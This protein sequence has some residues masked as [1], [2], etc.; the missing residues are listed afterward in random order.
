MCILKIPNIFFLCF[1]AK[2]L[3]S[4]SQESFEVASRTEESLAS[5]QR[6]PCRTSQRYLQDKEIHG[7]IGKRCVSTKHAHTYYLKNLNTCA[8]L[9]TEHL[10]FPLNTAMRGLNFFSF[11][12][13]ILP[14]SLSSLLK[15]KGKNTD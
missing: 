4:H 7:K 11:S 2:I 8:K 9:K 6:S 5:F 13:K 1:R 3:P 15:K 12:T 10:H 14:P